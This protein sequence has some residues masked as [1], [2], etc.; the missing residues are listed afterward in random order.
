MEMFGT[1]RV[2]TSNGNVVPFWGPRVSLP[3][4]FGYCVSSS[5]TDVKETHVV[6][7]GGGNSG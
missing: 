1:T 6:S 4:F 7:N 2:M 5:T 3:E